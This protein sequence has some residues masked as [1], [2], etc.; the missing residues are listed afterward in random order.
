MITTLFLANS[1]IQAVVGTRGKKVR[2]RKV[3]SA[4]IPEGSLINGIVT[5]EAELAEQLKTFWQEN[6]LPTKDVELVIN[7]SQFVL[8]QFTVPVMK[9]R[10]IRDAIP[11]EFSDV[12]DLSEAVFDYL[13]EKKTASK[14]L[15]LHAVM[16]DRGYLQGYL[17]LFKSIGVTV[18]AIRPMR[19]CLIRA[20][21]SLKQLHH[22]TCVILMV[23]GSIIS[24]NLWSEG[25]SIYNSQKRVFC[26]PGTEQFGYEI[27]RVL[28][29][30][31]QFAS[32]QNLS[33]QLQEVYLTGAAPEEFQIY[34]AILQEMELGLTVAELQPEKHIRIQKNCACN[35]WD[36]L[37]ELGVYLMR[38]EDVNLAKQAQKKQKKKSSPVE[39][40]KY[41]LPPVCLLIVAAAATGVLYYL[42]SQ[43]QQELDALNAYLNDPSNQAICEQADALEQ[44]NSVYA[45][46][47]Q[48][49]R[50]FNDILESYPHMNSTVIAQLQ[51]FAVP[52]MVEL[53]VKSYS[54]DNGSL[55]VDAKAEEVTLINQFIDILEASGIFDDIQY[56]GYVYNE[57]TM[58]YTIN[59]TCYLSENA[60]K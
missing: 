42:N 48:T 23:D 36:I 57:E 26:E 24:S 33:D 34:R 32:T 35:Y 60:G 10:K 18:T 38:R 1:N 15:P 2:I 37:P 58:L 11:L 8:K 13:A 55:S 46:R 27:A 4:K 21:Q 5:N 28:S 7:S 45:R 49:I 50:D 56:T 20:L 6:H 39:W 41:V 31:Q 17:Q 16:A 25:T 40:K 51:S 52:K 14:Q 53:E 29:N 54:A 44:L 19:I 12:N 47:I 22:K 59:V 43:K 9:D 30:I 3:C